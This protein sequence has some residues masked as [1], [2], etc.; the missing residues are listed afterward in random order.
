MNKITVIIP[1]LNEEKSISYVINSIPK[2]I[3]QIIVVDNGST[4]K[5]SVIA[6][7]KGAIIL[8][9][10]NKGYGYTCLKGIEFLKPNPPDIIVFLDGDFSDY[11]EDMDLLINPIINKN[12]DFVMGSRVKKLREP[13]SMTLQQVFGNSL[14]CFLLKFLYGAN[15]KD[16]GPFRAIKWKSLQK[17]NMEDKTF[18][19]TIE[20][21]L[22]AHKYKI[23]YMEVPVRYRNRIGKSK[24]SGTLLGTIMAGY[25]IL[26]WIFKY[27]LKK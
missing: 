6:K 12:Y 19:W 17:L 23:K 26:L 15:Y 5:T 25:K 11:P 16:L 21:Q 7:S 13:G 8:N 18:G 4:D 2:Y 24:I 3:N 9:E 1:A 10:L 14:A 27:Y 22:K 20:M